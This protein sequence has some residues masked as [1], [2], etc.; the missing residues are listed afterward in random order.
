MLKSPPPTD[1][2]NLQLQME[3]FPMKRPENKLNSI[4]TTTGPRLSEVDKWCP[5]RDLKSPWRIDRPAIRTLQKVVSRKVYYRVMGQS[6]LKASGF[7][8]LIH[9][10]LKEYGANITKQRI[11]KCLETVVEYNPWFP[12]EDSLDEE[13][14]IRVENNV[15][16]AM[17]QDRTQAA[18]PIYEGL[19][20]N[21]LRELKKACHL[22][23]PT[24]PYTIEI[25]KAWAN[26]G[27]WISHDWHMV[28]RACL[29]PQDLLQWKMWLSDAVYMKAWANRANPAMHH[30][31]FEML[32]G[33]GPFSDVQEQ[34][35]NT[36]PTAM[37]QVSEISLVAWGKLTPSGEVGQSYIKI[38]QGP[39][40][41]YTDFISR[42][43]MAIDRQ[44]D[45][46]LT[47]EHLL[48]Q[49]AF[50]NAN[51]DGQAAI[52]PHRETANILDYL[53]LCR[54]I[55]TLTHQARISSLQLMAL[56]KQ[57]DIKCYNC[58]KVGHVK[59]ECST[60][61]C[62]HKPSVLPLRPAT[63][64]SAIVDLTTPFT[65]SLHSG[66]GPQ[67]IP[68]GYYGPLPRGTVGLGLGRSSLNLKGIQVMTGVIDSDYEGEIMVVTQTRVPWTF[69]GGD[70]IAQ[71]LLLP[72]VQIGQSQQ[73]R[74][75]GF[76]STDPLMVKW[77][78]LLTQTDR[79]SM[80]LKV[81]GRTFSSLVDSGADI[82]VI[83]SQHWPNTW[84]TQATSSSVEGIGF[85]LAE[86]IQQISVPLKY[87]EP[88]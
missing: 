26:S 39:T 14:W 80:T 70:R 64:G 53:C 12:D 43:E 65:V 21:A 10:F 6:N 18:G 67:K 40:E 72:Y 54:N 35:V 62:T 59:K 78:S 4:T 52:R 16:K 86:E 48:R 24:A 41:A 83:A 7:A 42:L 69:K 1:T 5:N 11:K 44:V 88:D 13:T 47:K 3:K 38:V 79:P 50:E 17:R 84:P 32:T 45:H 76:G 46:K 8:V 61:C 63:Q 68:T 28:A 37:V 9:H 27:E 81:R 22:Y 29:K 36:P 34:L 58:G 77:A 33:S 74:R 31:S 55:G 73:I 87:E 23:G 20:L 51:E 30:I 66:L 2:T 25:L 71:L 60:S 49:F 15:L 56:Q 19:D 85:V 57:W 82:S 75:G